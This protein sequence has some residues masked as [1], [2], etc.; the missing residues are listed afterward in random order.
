MWFN[1]SRA[2]KLSGTRC[3]S[4]SPAYEQHRTRAAGFVHEQRHSQRMQHVRAGTHKIL[5]T[6]C[7]NQD[8]PDKRHLGT[9]G[10]SSEQ[11]E[12]TQ[13]CR[14]GVHERNTNSRTCETTRVTRAR[15]TRTR[16]QQQQMRPIL[17]KTSNA[18]PTKPRICRQM[19]WDP[20]DETKYAHFPT[21]VA[22]L[23]KATMAKVR[24]ESQRSWP[25]SHH[26]IL[27]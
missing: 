1:P 13:C 19:M 11:A 25:I 27:Q 23:R 5:D 2:Y 7:S 10:R 20:T 22:P 12:R 4:P 17:M 8:S 26:T 16:Q 15:A 21:T 14:T 9:G 24:M 3:S 6:C 18:P